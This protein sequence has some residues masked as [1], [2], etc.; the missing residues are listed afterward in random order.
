M[1]KKNPILVAC[2]WPYANGSLHVGHVSALLPADMLTRFFFLQGHDVLLVSGSDAHGTP[3]TVRANKEGKNPEDIARHYHEEMKSNLT[4]LGF[5]FD[6][7]GLYSI[8]TSKKHEQV[9][10]DIFLVLQKK[11]YIEKRTE[12]AFW[13]EIDKRFLPDRYIEGE[14]PYCH[15]D[16]AR[17][18]Q[19]DNCGKLLDPQELINPK[20]KLSGDTPVQKDTEHFYFLLSKVEKPLRIYLDSLTHMRKNTKD[21]TDKFIKEGLKDRAITRDI[22]W[23]VPVPVQGYETKRIYVWFEAV[24]GYLSASKEWAENKG[25]P[26]AWEE[27]WLQKDT[28]SFYIYGKDNIPFHTIIW[29]AILLAYNNKLNMPT[30]HVSSEYVQIE[31]KKL[32]TSRNW[33][34]WIPDLLKKFSQDVLRFTFISFGP[35]TSDTNFSF[36]ELQKKYNTEFVAILGN[37]IQRVVKLSKKAGI[38]TV[39]CNLATDCSAQI[40][41]EVGLKIQNGKFRDAL[42]DILHFATVGNKYLDHHE[43]WKKI[44]TNHEHAT[45]IL[46]ESLIRSA[47]IGI[48]L[49][50]FLPKAS[51]TICAMLGFTVSSYEPYKGI[52][53]IKEIPD[54]L[55][56]R[57]EDAV[58]I[59]EQNKLVS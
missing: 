13:S 41:T 46:S 25:V 48:L 8:T 31:G 45:Q 52:L 30:T 6:T 36:Q 56:P 9:V 59:Q 40:F 35:E 10:Q 11:G 57:V 29:P 38:K 44:K 43:P 5:S 28:Q 37:F 32:S 42:Q 50:P 19:C 51:E 20:S 53:E 24:C 54:I 7:H 39:D 55:F 1:A 12:K 58:I 22:E 4:A 47:Y 34:V 17:G 26:R 14:C 23:G 21:F 16:P 49:A 27:F 3:I 33:A 15:F 18:D 2:A